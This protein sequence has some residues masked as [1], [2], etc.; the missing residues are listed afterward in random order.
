MTIN[1]I[2]ILV[3]LAM[4]LTGASPADMP[5]EASRTLRIS[6]VAISFGDAEIERADRASDKLYQ[7]MDERKQTGA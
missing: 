2:A 4:M 7:S 1:I 3:S 6:D 5:A